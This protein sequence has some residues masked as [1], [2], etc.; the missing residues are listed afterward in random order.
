MQ[1]K[2]EFKHPSII[3]RI[4]SS[5]KF[6]PRSQR[7]SNLSDEQIGALEHLQSYGYAF[8]DGRIDAE[9]LEYLQ[10]KTDAKIKSGEVNFPVLAQTKI[11]PQ[12]HKSLIDNY[13]LG[14]GDFFRKN[15]IAFNKEEFRSYE[16]VIKEFNP[17]TLEFRIPENDK[18]F[19]QVWLNPF[20]LDIVEAY[21]GYRPNLVEAYV[22]R[23]F[24]SPYRTMN[25]FW[26]RDLNDK[27][28][29]LKSFIFLSDC[30]LD[31]GPHEY[32]KGSHKDFKLNGKVYYSDEDVNTSHGEDIV[33]K[34]VKAGTILIEDTRG[35][36][37]ASLPEKGHR[38]LGFAVFF[39]LP[40]YR[41]YRIVNYK[42]SPSVYSSLTPEQQKY[43]LRSSL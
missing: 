42:T 31:N 4:K 40:W 32:V 13:L 21:M 39:P 7:I 41:P 29:L 14:T 17:S 27:F 9:T 11:D 20:V 6:F 36:H 28:F 38:D 1:K 3:D 10:A 15:G 35:L 24:P 2:F 5:L 33:R 26:H 34:K 12:K 19:F 30:E 16:Q 37:R 22:R 18:T 25:H 23:N 8:I 43:I